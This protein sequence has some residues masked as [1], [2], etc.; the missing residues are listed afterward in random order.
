[1]KSQFL[2][3]VLPLYV[4]LKRS[5]SGSAQVPQVPQVI[6]QAAETPGN[7]QRFVLSFCPTHVQYL[8][9]YGFTLPT[10]GIFSLREESEHA[11]VGELLGVAVVGASVSIVGDPDGAIGAAEGLGDGL[12]D[13]VGVLVGSS[14]GALLGS[15]LGGAKGTVEGASLGALLGSKLGS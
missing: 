12:M 6:G 15:K 10:V 13:L 5:S 8:D 2:T 4:N 11:T 14:L 9:T 7:A 1:M 3:I